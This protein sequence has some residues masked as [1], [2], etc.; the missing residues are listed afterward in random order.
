MGIFKLFIRKAKAEEIS[1]GDAVAELRKEAV[2]RDAIVNGVIKDVDKLNEQ[3]FAATRI[4]PEEATPQ[5]K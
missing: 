5:K 3:L 2:A 4:P 1:Q